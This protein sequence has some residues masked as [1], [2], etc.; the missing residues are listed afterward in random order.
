MFTVDPKP[1][2]IT[3]SVTALN[4]SFD[5][6]CFSSAI[7]TDVGYTDHMSAGI[8]TCPALHHHPS[9]PMSSHVG[10]SVSCRIHM[11]FAASDFSSTLTLEL[12]N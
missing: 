7:Y 3:S 2:Q 11:A 6:F 10:A 4:I 9:S 5:L 8:Q 1:S 12:N